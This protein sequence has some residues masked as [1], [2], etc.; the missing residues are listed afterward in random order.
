MTSGEKLP[1]G[2]KVRV[3]DVITST[4]VEVEPVLEPERTSNA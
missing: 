4:T 1:S 3:V 2:A